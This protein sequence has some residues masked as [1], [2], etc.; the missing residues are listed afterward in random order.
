VLVYLQA[1]L[2]FN[3]TDWWQDALSLPQA[4]SCTTVLSI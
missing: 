2:V 4:V 1:L 3:Y